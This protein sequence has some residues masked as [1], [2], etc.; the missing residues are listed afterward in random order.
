MRQGALLT[1]STTNSYTQQELNFSM[2]WSIS[3]MLYESLLVSDQS[4]F[5]KHMSGVQ[6]FAA[7]SPEARGLA[8]FTGKGA[9]V[10]CHDGPVLSTAAVV[11]EGGVTNPPL[12]PLVVERMLMASDG[13]RPAIYDIGFYNIGVRPTVEDVGIGGTDPWG[14]PL[15]FTRQFVQQ[16]PFARAVANQV[17]K[18]PFKVD[19]C[20]WEHR[21]TENAPETCGDGSPELQAMLPAEE[22]Q[23]VDGAFK[24]PTLRNVGLTAPYFHNGGYATLESV[25]RFYGRGGNR[26]PAQSSDEIEADDNTGTGL[27]GNGDVLA[28]QNKGSNLAAEIEAPNAEAADMAEGLPASQVP[29]E[30]FSDQE[31]S[32]LVAFL[33][34]LTDSR[35]ACRKGDF[36]HPQLV[37][38]H[39]HVD[40]PSKSTGNA[41]DYWDAVLPATG[42]NGSANC[43]NNSGDLFVR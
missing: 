4:P 25:V 29:A 12:D 15:S 14:N 11:A 36:D 21:V 30:G 43:F 24:T 13:S 3:I 5:D 20:L 32:D 40:D 35:V 1:P 9:C 19:P 10:D 38:P 26:R 8:L 6:P 39:G 37:I 17:Y 7:N 23:A 16:S 18:D 22:R 41:A 42:R 2:F 34:S 28:N 33:L 27:L 31:V